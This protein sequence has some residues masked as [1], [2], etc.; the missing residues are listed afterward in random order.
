MSSLVSL[1][2]SALLLSLVQVAAAIPWLAVL[3]RDLFRSAKRRSDLLSWLGGALVGVAL[4]VGL[5]MRAAGWVDLFGRMYGAVL[6]IQLVVDLFVLAFFVLLKLWPRGGAVALAAF[7]ESVRQPMYW[8][9]FAVTASFLVISMVIPYFTFGDD[10]KMMSNLGFDVI[11]LATAL[12][13]VLAASLSIYE[14][15]EG[16]TAVT[17][18]SKP[19]TRR[20]FLLGKFLGILLACFALTCLLG[21]CLNWTMHV[22]PFMNRLDDAAD[23][24]AQQMQAVLAPYVQKVAP[25]GDA[26]PFVAG[27]NAWLGE[28]LARHLGLILGFGQV[29]ILV[30]VAS[31]LA[32]RMPF[33]VNVVLVLMVFFLGHLAPVLVRFSASLNFGGARLVGF[34]AQ[35]LDVVL[36]ALEFFNMG[37]VIIRTTA[38]RLSEYA[39]YV[40]QVS[41]YALIY[42]GIALLF[43]LIL[44]EDRDLA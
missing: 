22:Q 33:V 17:L 44:F 10:F 35:A 40:G 43:G 20:D 4:L 1:A 30:A 36:P 2:L 25:G 16:R 26:A 41:V 27:V 34:L 32:T 19:V 8:L 38:L 42:T 7:R 9:I 6:H 12:F 14:E 11:M 21:W 31:A 23:P 39:L 29:M 24:L 18:M 15:I 13:G 5:G 28:A 37:P 3:D